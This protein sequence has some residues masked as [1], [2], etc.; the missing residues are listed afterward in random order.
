MAGEEIAQMVV[1]AYPIEGSASPSDPARDAS[2]AFADAVLRQ[3]RAE[4][5]VLLQAGRTEEAETLMEQRR[6]ELA[7]AGIVYRRINQAFFAARS[8]YADT[9]ASIDPLGPKL[10][11]LR[12]RSASLDEFL[13]TAAELESEGD[14]DR[15]LATESYGSR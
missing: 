14:L 12:A 15:E 13:A 9:G 2:S 3:L 5:E 6:D 11:R 8:F 4:V 10:E 1:V 7:E